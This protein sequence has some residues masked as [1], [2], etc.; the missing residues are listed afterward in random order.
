MGS[1]GFQVSSV[2]PATPAEVWTRAGTI[3]GVN[4]ELLPFARMTCP[5]AFAGMRLDDATA[6]PG[7]RLFRSWILLFGVLPI[8]W[9]DLTLVRVEPDRGFLESSTM[10]SQRRW[11]HERTLE[12]VPGGCRVTDRIEFEPRLSLPS[13]LFL[14]VF[15]FFFQHRHRRLARWF[16]K[17]TP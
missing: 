4:Y 13:G 12:H 7:E 10:L 17:A 5:R 11:I 3:E 6:T 8:D 16:G 14:G 15:R 9:D 1:G 2:V